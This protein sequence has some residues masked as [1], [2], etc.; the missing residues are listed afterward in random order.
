LA[1]TEDPLE[2][3]GGIGGTP[4]VSRTYLFATDMNWTEGSHTFNRRTDILMAGEEMSAAFASNIN[5]SFQW[6]VE[7]SSLTRTADGEFT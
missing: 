6:Y 4:V 5:G 2:L 1:I 7:N 3:W